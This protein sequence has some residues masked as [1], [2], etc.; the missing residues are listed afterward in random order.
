MVIFCWKR[1]KNLLNAANLYLF[2]SWITYLLIQYFKRDEIFTEINKNS[3]L[4]LQMLNFLE[5]ESICFLSMSLCRTQ[6][7]KHNDDQL[8][9][10]VLK[11]KEKCI[12]KFSFYSQSEIYKILQFTNINCNN[13]NS[14]LLKINF[15][16]KVKLL[17]I[18][19][20]NR[21]N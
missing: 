3:S 4:L 12:L 13:N 14:T 7:S 15:T 20:R 2:C 5:T 9:Y 16:L 1:H 19:M 17:K 8:L 6:S 10:F 11:R 18:V 21:F